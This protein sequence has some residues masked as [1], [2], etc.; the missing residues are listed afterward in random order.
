LAHLVESPVCTEIVQIS[1]W[2]QTLAASSEGIRSLPEA[3]LLWWRARLSED[4]TKTERA[5]KVLDWAELTFVI[6]LCAG[7]AGWIARNWEALKTPLAS[8]SAFSSRLLSDPVAW[9][10]NA[11][12]GLSL[13]G[14]VMLSL[15]AIGLAFPLFAR[16]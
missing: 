10:L 11:A 7:L 3:G 2:M 12:A 6:L 16:D 9:A 1:G 5:Q 8:L 14:L 15:V 13:F 4:L